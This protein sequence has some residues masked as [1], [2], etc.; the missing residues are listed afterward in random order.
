MFTWPHAL[1]GSRCWPFERYPSWGLGFPLKIWILS[2]LCLCKCHRFFRE[3]FRAP[4]YA[5]FY[6]W[7]ILKVPETSFEAYWFRMC[8][9]EEGLPNRFRKAIYIWFSWVLLLE[10]STIAEGLL[11]GFP[12]SYCRTLTSQYQVFVFNSEWLNHLQLLL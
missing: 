8:R 6:L 7:L 12:K 2:C 10:F 1:L 4:R 5:S 3:C 11:V 9:P